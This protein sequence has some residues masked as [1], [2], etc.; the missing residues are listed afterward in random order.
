LG[1]ALI[2]NVWDAFSYQV[3]ALSDTAR[4]LGGF[5]FRLADF[6]AWPRRLVVFALLTKLSLHYPVFDP[7]V[8]LPLFHT[9]N[10]GN[11]RAFA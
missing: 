11:G 8:D 6:L 1:L 9:A 4:R 5:F 7:G 3:A 10:I 2:P